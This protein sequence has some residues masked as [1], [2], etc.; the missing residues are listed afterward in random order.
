MLY[1]VDYEF[2]S[3]NWSVGGTDCTVEEASEFI[4]RRYIW[5]HQ[6]KIDNIMKS[7]I[8]ASKKYAKN[9]KN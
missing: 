9:K 1:K 6:T 4:A 2:T 7:I 3:G 8:K 5:A